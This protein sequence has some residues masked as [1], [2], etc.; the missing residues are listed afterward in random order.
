MKKHST[1]NA[2]SESISDISTNSV[3]LQNN[4][5]SD[6]KNEDFSGSDVDKK[7]ETKNVTLTSTST[8][9]ASTASSSI[10]TLSS[11]DAPSSAPSSFIKTTSSS[12]STSQ[13]SN[14]TP[15]PSPYTSELLATTISSSTSSTSH[16]QE[17]KNISS[18]LID[19]AIEQ[20]T[21]SCDEE[22]AFTPAELVT[23]IMKKILEDMVSSDEKKQFRTNIKNALELKN[24]DRIQ[25]WMHS[26]IDDLFNPEGQKEQK[27]HNNQIT[28]DKENQEVPKNI[29]KTLITQLNSKCK[30]NNCALPQLMIAVM[31]KMRDDMSPQNRLEFQNHLI[32]TLE[33]EKAAISKQKMMQFCL[34]LN[35][36][37]TST[38]QSHTTSTVTV[39][40]EAVMHFLN[41][42]VEC[43]P[44]GDREQFKT[45][46]SKK[47]G[48]SKQLVSHD[49]KSQASQATS[50]SPSS[51]SSSSSPITRKRPIFE[52]SK[53]YPYNCWKT[54]D[55]KPKQLFN[56]QH[57][58]VYGENRP[59]YREGPMELYKAQ[60]KYTEENTTSPVEISTTIVRLNKK[61]CPLEE[62][63]N[64]LYFH[65]DLER[66]ATFKHDNLVNITHIAHVKEEPSF[67]I[68]NLSI[69]TYEP[70]NKWIP[71]FL[72]SETMDE[73][74]TA[75]NRKITDPLIYPI[76]TSLIDA[77]SY[78][79]EKKYPVKRLSL[80]KIYVNK[81]TEHCKLVFFNF[82]T[83]T[84][85]VE[86]VE[87]ID[88]TSVKPDPDDYWKMAA[89]ETFYSTNNQEA[90]TTTESNIY[91][92]A[93][94][95]CKLM[96]GFF[97]YEKRLKE[98]WDKVDNN[99]P[100]GRKALANIMVK[101]TK[102][103]NKE[104]D[105]YGNCDA[106]HYP[107]GDLLKPLLAK[108]PKDRKTLKDFKDAFEKFKKDNPDHPVSSD[109]T[110]SAQVISGFKPVDNQHSSAS[111]SSSSSSNPSSRSTSSAPST[112]PT[113]KT[114]S[115]SAPSNPP[116]SYN[117][118][119]RS[120]D[121]V[122]NSS[123]ANAFFS[124]FSSSS[125]Q[126]SA[127][128]SGQEKKPS[129]TSTSTPRI[130]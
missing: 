62:G 118:A 54:T 105:A 92:L 45:E 12:V 129:E 39:T 69:F 94:I 98:Q 70:L 78:L 14:N 35:S 19:Q 71:L 3:D 81:K 8:A 108:N 30:K 25:K 97:P 115:I 51:P 24:D 96:T 28:Q 73:K 107:G 101:E 50:S 9:L 99:A 49:S 123:N 53:T 2:F 7:A 83:L 120:V 13:T 11:N 104:D 111:S 48:D 128:N 100:L 95:I 5:N 93:A 84:Q 36:I 102:D 10:S 61:A 52:E 80:S 42:A 65:Y 66:I 126:S 114:S 47:Y 59:F 109:P 22:D 125:S 130:P 44:E 40:W 122:S 56:R 63:L 26:Q 32:K 82:D 55:G 18:K 67:L 88:Q 89:P 33:L 43:M 103:E 76:I 23:A 90:V 75:N 74:T 127:L 41:T 86:Y 106:K 16:Q 87:Y 21:E 15:S 17:N 85:H 58:K 34:L 6:D 117:S 38:T 64:L 113:N 79:E 72:P 57:I 91:S 68:E 116:P 20:I 31:N 1:S 112:S 46:M 110:S 60:L 121:N 4:N 119:T 124:N 27:H 77:L 29:V 37:T